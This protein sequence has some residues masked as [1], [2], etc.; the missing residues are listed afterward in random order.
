MLHDH[1]T[2]LE[3]RTRRLQNNTAPTVPVY[4]LDSMVPK[5]W[6]IR[7]NDWDFGSNSPGQIAWSEKLGMFIIVALG[8]SPYSELTS[9]DGITWTGRAGP[10]TL[11]SSG[12]WGH[13]PG[14]DV[15]PRYYSGKNRQTSDGLSWSITPSGFSD[16]VAAYSPTLNRWVAIHLGGNTVATSDD[17]GTTWTNRTT[18]W[19]SRSPDVFTGMWSAI[20]NCFILA[21]DTAAPYHTVLRSDDGIAW[22]S[23]STP[24]D[25]WSFC[26]DITESPRLGKVFIAGSGNSD[27]VTGVFDP[28]HSSVIQ[29]SDGGLTWTETPP[30]FDGIIGTFAAGEAI[31]IIDDGQNV[32]VGGYT[33]GFS[34]RAAFLSPNGNVEW[35]NAN[36]PFDG[37]YSLAYSP[38]LDVVVATGF[39]G[40]QAR[41]ATYGHP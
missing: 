20:F 24:L 21:G 30:M 25:Q 27:P 8:N 40:P 4:D 36:I 12:L 17:N 18:P 38:S 3:N 23:V 32:I 15:Q 22:Q 5:V 14:S 31:C 41:I 11:Q 9:T 28:S 34:D 6:T 2:H 19:D 35:V 26:Y 39:L 29:S 16:E 33:N 7:H 37:V 1:I 10:G 13:L